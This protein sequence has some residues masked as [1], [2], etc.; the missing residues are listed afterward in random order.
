MTAEDEE[1]SR[2]Y[3]SRSGRRSGL[4]DGLSPDALTPILRLHAPTSQLVNYSEIR[5]P[6]P[7]MVDS[8]ASHTHTHTYPTC[9]MAQ[10]ST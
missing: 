7:E 1:A 5:P 9:I 3:V 10:S 4:S 6:K 8:Q 2:M